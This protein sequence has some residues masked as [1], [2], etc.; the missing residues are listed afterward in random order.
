MSDRETELDFDFFEEP[1]TQEAPARARPSRRPRGPVRPPGGLTPLLRLVG[2]IAFAIAVI[3]VL[4]LAVQSCR[5]D[6]KKDKYAD[7][8]RAV[9]GIARDSQSVGRQ[10]S[11]LLTEPSVKLPAIQSKLDGLV[12]QQE[13]DV[14][15]AR[16][17]TPPGRLRVQHAQLVEALQFRRSGLQRL[18]EAFRAGAKLKPAP[19][20]KLLAEQMRR[21]V[22]SDVIWEDGFQAGSEAVLRREDVNGVKPPA[23]VFLR[24]PETASAR[25]L[26]SYWQRIRGATTG[27]R[28][29]GPHGNALVSVKALPDNLVLQPG[30]DNLVVASSDLAFQAT[31]EN[32]GRSQE[33]RVRVRL[34]V[35]QK[36]QPITKQQIIDVIN[37]GQRK[38][39]TFANLSPIVKFS[40]PIP[41]RVEVVPVKGETRT[42][43]NSA[44]YT[45][46][47]RIS[48]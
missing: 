31:V 19:A 32:S 14:A 42:Q 44:T 27:T 17:L 39:V 16:E 23:S 35:D 33:V 28:G 43:N 37:P 12:D 47:F 15:H 48:Q 40:E 7:Y 29:P 41:V 34:R 36:P 21:L 46:T 13:Q 8:M 9:N 45:V 18:G 38:T 1:E 2:L 5:S 25:V 10:L 24:D 20:G 3:V 6:D 22:A 30:Q 11:A 26:A 4:V